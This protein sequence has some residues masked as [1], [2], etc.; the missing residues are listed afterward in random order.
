M[1]KHSIIVLFL[2]IALLMGIVYTP[3]KALSTTGWATGIKLQNLSA[4]I[5]TITVALTNAAGIQ[6]AAITTTVG[7]APLTVAGNSSIE[8]FLPAYSTVPGG[9]YS[10]TVSSDVQLGTVATMTNYGEGIADSYNSMVPAA[11]VFVPYVYHNHNSWN[12][13]IYVQN[14]NI[15]Q[16]TGTLELREP[17][18]GASSSDG[19]GDEDVPFT[20][21]PFGIF[22]FDASTHADLKWFIGAATV[23]ASAS[24]AVN[25]NQIRLTGAGD[26]P[27]NVLIQSRGVASADA[28]SVLTFPSLYK[29]FTGVNGTWQSGIKLQ[30]PG[31]SPVEVVVAF[32]QNGS[33][34]PLGTSTFI[35]PTNGNKELFLPGVTLD[36]GGA[37]PD[38]FLG[39]G[40]ATVNTAGGSI[41]GNVQHTNYTAAGGFGVA[42]GYTAFATGK[43]KVS[44]PSLY[45]WPS[46][47][48]IWVSGIKIQNLGSA[49]VDVVVTL[50]NDPDSPTF[51]GTK[52]FLNI[53]P[54]LAVELYLPV[55]GILDGG[56]SIP[57]TWKGSAMVVATG[58]NPQIVATVIHTNYGRHVANMY[59]GIPVP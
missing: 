38:M 34:T 27:G 21:P 46:G 25:A 4:T 29:G 6:T 3:A 41:M 35:I 24:V 52:T 57:S 45:N 18:G 1:K 16:V 11:T 50:Q 39:S 23:R 2:I 9:E 8:I 5:G 48:G 40:V 20:I 58:T 47:A 22:H 59:T 37:I 33:V 56:L 54:G 32:T 7:G 12:T 53:A 44:L 28:G 51:T 26:V 14:V 31:A 43:A 55:G 17:V 10:A 19:L 15:V 42:E 36:G 30:N 49:T 13:E